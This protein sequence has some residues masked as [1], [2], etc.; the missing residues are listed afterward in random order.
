MQVCAISK[1]PPFQ[2]ESG[3]PTGCITHPPTIPQPSPPPES[4]RRGRS[5]HRFRSGGH[6]GH[7][8]RSGGDRHISPLRS[9]KILPPLRSE[10]SLPP[11]RSS[12]ARQP[13]HRSSAAL[14]TP[15]PLHSSHHLRYTGS[16]LQRSPTHSRPSITAGPSAHSSTPP[17]HPIFTNVN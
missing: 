16:P 12:A 7:R 9:E 13:P 1:P 10:K 17:L 6:A 5:G 3:S 15:P 11:L 2:G 14:R 8:F 4:G